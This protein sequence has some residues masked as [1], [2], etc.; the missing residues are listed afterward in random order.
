[1]IQTFSTVLFS[2]PL[3]KKRRRERGRR[4]K[5]KGTFFS[6][7]GKKPERINGETHGKE[8]PRTG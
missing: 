3:L 5:R 4:R 1:M 2:L 8:K 7:K 6:N